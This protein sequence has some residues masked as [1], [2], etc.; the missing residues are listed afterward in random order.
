[1]RQ[2]LFATKTFYPLLAILAA[3]FFITS[4]VHAAVITSGE[5]DPADTDSWATS[6]AVY[7]GYDSTGT[8]EITEASSVSNVRDAY[9][10]Y[11]ADSVGTVIVDGD[12]SLWAS[13]RNIYVGYNGTGTIAITNGG[14]VTSQ[15]GMV[16]TRSNGTVTIDGQ[17][18]S[19]VTTAGMYV[20][21]EGYEGAGSLAITNGG[22]MTTNNSFISYNSYNTGTVTVDGEGSTWTNA[23][24]LYVGRAGTGTLTVTNGGSVFSNPTDGE[25]RY[26]YIGATKNSTGTV[27]INGE[28]STWTDGNKIYVGKSGVG[29][30]AVTDSAQ[31]STKELVIN[32]SSTVTVDMDSSLKIGTTDDWTGYINNA[33]TI[34]L[35]AG[36]AV[37]SGTYSPLSYGTME[38]EGVVRVLGGVWNEESMNVTV[39]DAVTAQGLGGTSATFNLSDNQRALITDTATNK[40]AGVS[41]E[42]QD[43]DITLTITALTDLDDLSNTTD[44]TILS[45]W[46]I[47]AQGY[48]VSEDNPV[49]LSLFAGSSEDILDLT[50]WYLVNGV[51][52]EYETSDFAFDG[53]FASFTATELGTFAVTST[54]SVPV[55]GTLCLLATGLL[56]M[57]AVRRKSLG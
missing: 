26:S 23:Y 21:V 37:E 42:A 6:T 43:S 32:S 53:T 39:S 10:G 29:R 48:T 15:C 44:E 56:G 36:S 40:S 20:G 31:V 5:L 46:T 25:Y 12:G 49:Y 4:A 3:A 8:L 54:S 7:I 27:L 35:V 1:M 28:G 24:N 55:P 11:N 51:W 52:T 41:F 14:S 33:G 45:A 2:I 38:G 19:W 30:L 47:L 13:R 57:A 16:G 50:I 9:L 34:N 18:S 22:S 17:G